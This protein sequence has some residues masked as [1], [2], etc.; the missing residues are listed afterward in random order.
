MA[1]RLIQFPQFPA[2]ST[3]YARAA[4]EILSL[5]HES[6]VG[7]VA[8]LFREPEVM[9]EIAS[10]VRELAH[11]EFAIAKSEAEFFY[12]YLQKAETK[13]GLFDEHEYF[14]GEF[15]LVAGTACRQLT[16]RDEA[17][18]W[19]DRAEAGY[20]HTVNAI[21]DLSR[22]AY[23]RLALRL[24]ER[25][26]EAVLELAPALVQNFAKLGMR[27]DEIKGR[28]LRS[29]A[30]MESD[31]LQEAADEF[32]LIVSVAADLRSERL[33]AQAYGNLTHIYGLMGDSDNA[34][35]CSQLSIPA[36]ERLGDRFAIAK[37]RWG[38]ANLLRKRG[39]IGA[40][41]Q[42][43]RAAQA[44]FAEIGMR[45]DVA[46]LNLVIA[47]LQLESGEEKE[48]LTSV[49]SAIPTLDELDMIPEGLAAMS[50]LRES[51]RKR[52]INRSALRE[53]HGYFDDVQGR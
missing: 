43:Y 24:E 46:A 38:L 42:A 11:S 10:Q 35:R 26:L 21:A 44:G 6:R 18:L 30:L 53:L 19:F 48:A 25:Q 33:V 36:L 37:V 14:L 7:E 2:S 50:L 47:D 20:R 1:G 49:L 27:E 4:R 51:V 29:L 3:D 52:Q 5:S 15:A 8:E 16:L 9:L 12:G 39:E 23:Q 32:T 13:I 17:R 41:V 34:I 22:L 28:F 31:Q 40:A 45:A